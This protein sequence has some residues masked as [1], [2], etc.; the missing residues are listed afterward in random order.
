M[1]FHPSTILFIFFLLFSLTMMISL[2]SWFLI[3]FFIEMNLLSFIPLIL[4]KKNKYCV[5][6]SLK[7]F[8]IQTLSS[9][10]ILVGL[11]LMF[12]DMGI[13]EFFFIGGLSI[14]LGFA[15]FHQWV[16]NVVEGLS[17]PL[18]G[19]L[20]TIQKVGPFI[21]LGYLYA[22]KE[23]LSYV[24]YALSLVSSFFGCVGGLFTSSLR[25]ILVFSSISHA[26]WMILGLISSIYL[27]GLYFIFYIMI[28]FSVMSILNFYNLSNLNH[29]FLKLS[30][31]SSLILGV[32][33]LSM[34]GMPPMTGFVSKFIVMKEFIVLYNFF[35]LIFLLTSVFISLFFYSRVFMFNFIFL[36]NKNLFL[37]S[38]KKKL[39]YPLFVNISGF[40]LIPFIMGVL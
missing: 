25:K 3:W 18:V 26:S 1:F 10:L 27:W 34:G 19:L 2:N 37:S 21:L 9:I 28:L 23:N 15:P 30:F 14:K 24:I 5:E 33:V 4:V 31:F 36:V 35:I 13:Y 17:W 6:S 22:M 32:S 12:M 8:F 40:V 7:Y 39:G 16:V 29:M 38:D 20:L 11:V